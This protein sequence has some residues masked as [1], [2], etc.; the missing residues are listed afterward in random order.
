[1]AHNAGHWRIS[2]PRWTAM[3]TWLGEALT[4]SRSGAGYA[5]VVRHSLWTFGPATEAD[6]VW[7]LGATQAVVRTALADVHAIEVRL[8]DGAAGGVLPDVTAD[9]EAPPSK[10]PW[11]ALLP[12]LDPTTM[13][14]RDR[15]F[16]LDPVHMPYLFDRAGNGGTTIWVN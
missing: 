3:A 7:W 11:V 8:E 9:L 1:R 4:P 14:W 6:L 15:G 16:Y 12:V 5:E 13:G 10:E 2:R